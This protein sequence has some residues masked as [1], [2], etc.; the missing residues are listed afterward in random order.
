VASKVGSVFLHEV[1]L[2]GG[3]RGFRTACKWSECSWAHPSACTHFGCAY[4][5]NL[6]MVACLMVVGSGYCLG[7]L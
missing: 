2:M 4:F 6:V 3:E 7:K 1:E 5:A